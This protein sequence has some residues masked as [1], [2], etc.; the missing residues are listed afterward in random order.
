M[1]DDEQ[2]DAGIGGGDGAGGR[3]EWGCRADWPH[4]ASTTG[5]VAG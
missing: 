2:M 1:S 5:S 4:P 3:D